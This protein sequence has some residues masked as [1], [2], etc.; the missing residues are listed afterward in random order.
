MCTQDTDKPRDFLPDISMDATP[1][2]LPVE[3][4]RPP[5]KRR[6]SGAT[7]LNGAESTSI[8]YQQGNFD[9]ETLF[10]PNLTA[11]TVTACTATSNSTLVT[12]TVPVWSCTSCPSSYNAILV[13]PKSVWGPAGIPSPPP[14]YSP[15]S[16]GT[17]MKVTP[18]TLPTATHFSGEV[19]NFVNST[20]QAGPSSTNFITNPTGSGLNTIGSGP[21]TYTSLP[22]LG[23]FTSKTGS[24]LRLTF[25][26]GLISSSIA[27]TTGAPIPT[28][29][30][31]STRAVISTGGTV[32][33]GGAIPTGGIISAGE[34]SSTGRGIST[35]P[36]SGSVPTTGP[37]HTAASNSSTLADFGPS[38][39][40]STVVTTGPSGTSTQLVPV[41]SGGQVTSPIPAT[42]TGTINPTGTEASSSASALQSQLVVVVPVIQSLIDKP[43]KDMANDAINAIKKVQPLAEVYIVHRPYLIGFQLTDDPGTVC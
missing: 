9:V 28:G 6:D 22:L 40:T 42:I 20:T 2:I 32:S 29:G 35:G 11:N 1:I 17:D 38:L 13:S 19:Y 18:V 7:L 30:A 16:V 24:P 26:S 27:A 37:S 23:N 21:G 14:G 36:I 25:Q 41:I 8:S 12:T 33:K 15:L 10:F 5:L 43:G 34:A 31:N 4:G 39:F 3:A